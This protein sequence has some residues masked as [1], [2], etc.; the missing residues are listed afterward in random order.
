MC[1]GCR[2]TYPNTSPYT[3][4]QLKGSSRGVIKAVNIVE[5]PEGGEQSPSSDVSIPNP[6]AGQ[7]GPATN[8]VESSDEK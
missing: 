5:A 1:G 2:V 3:I 8:E 7:S 6:V 4:E